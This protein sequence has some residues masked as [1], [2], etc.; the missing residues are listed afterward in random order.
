MTKVSLSSIFSAIATMCLLTSAYASGGGVGAATGGASEF[1]QIANNMELATSVAKQSAMVTEQITARI[2]LL[3][4]YTTMITNLKNIPQNIIQETLAPYQTQLDA[5]RQLQG[6]VSNLRGAADSTRAMF[7][8]RGVD[9]RNSGM[10]MGS[11][12]KYELALAN[13]KGGIYR[14]RM[15]QDFASMDA[16]RDKASALR[17]TAAKTSA[18]TGNVQGL[19]QLSQLSAMQA[20]ELMEIKSTLLS[21]SADRN[22]DNAAKEEDK[23]QRAAAFGSAG[24]EAGKRSTRNG[25]TTFAVPSLFGAPVA[26]Q[27]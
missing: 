2:T 27:Q 5:F 9:F 3:N 23:S 1:T 8:S 7:E 25:S 21:Q 13:K 18:I 16:L 12:L 17:S 19:Q 24:N 22:M 11:F 20:G 15:D 4:Q 14:Q 26:P 10:D 6:S